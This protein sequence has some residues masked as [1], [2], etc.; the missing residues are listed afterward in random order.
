MGLAVAL[1]VLPRLE[2]TTPLLKTFLLGATMG[3][4]IYGVYDMTNLS[5]LKN[6]PLPFVVADMAWG[7]FVFGAVTVITGKWVS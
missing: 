3:L 4:I 2:P 5:I 1:L 7:A 6:H